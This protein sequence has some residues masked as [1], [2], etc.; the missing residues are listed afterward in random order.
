LVISSYVEQFQGV[1]IAEALAASDHAEDHYYGFKL[2]EWERRAKENG[3]NVAEAVYH[4]LATSCLMMLKP[5]SR[6]EPFEPFAVFPPNRSAIPSDISDGELDLFQAVAPSIS[7]HEVRAR[8]ADLVWVRR[9]HFPSVLIA[10]DAYLE[11]AANLALPMWHSAV[12]RFRR[13]ITLAASIRNEGEYKKVVAAI[14]SAL[15]GPEHSWLVEGLMTILLDYQEGDADAY[16]AECE[17]RSLVAEEATGEDRL[18]E[19]RHMWRWLPDGT[20]AR[21]GRTMSVDAN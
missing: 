9:R 17:R 15:A 12:E 7:D 5:E 21:S 10:I 4:I 2:Q 19:A 18:R 20:G 8:I 11:S 6:D 13:A 1:S 14:E 16:A 3:D